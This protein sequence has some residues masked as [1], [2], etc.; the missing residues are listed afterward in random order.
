[1]ILA[2]AKQKPERGKGSD[3]Y[4]TLREECASWSKKLSSSSR[5]M[6]GSLLSHGTSRPELQDW[7]ERLKVSGTVL[8]KKA[9]FSAHMSGLSLEFEANKLCVSYMKNAKF[10]MSSESKMKSKFFNIISIKDKYE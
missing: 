5:I 8:L 6:A 3:G 9:Y 1:M 2:V 4:V 7:K 10:A